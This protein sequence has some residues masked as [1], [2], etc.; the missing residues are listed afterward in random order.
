MMGVVYFLLNLAGEDM[1]E[2]DK[3]GTEAIERIG[4][5][6]GPVFLDEEMSEPCKA[7]TQ[8]R[9]SSEEVP[10]HGDKPSAEAGNNQA[11]TD[12]VQGAI[13]GVRMLAEIIRIETPER[14]I[15]FICHG[16]L[17]VLSYISTRSKSNLS[18]HFF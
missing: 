3:V 14:F 11:C 1:P 2:H 7:I 10:A 6:S 5:C 18:S 17:F 9:N 16:Y 13:D 8:D 4:E 15:F 12:E